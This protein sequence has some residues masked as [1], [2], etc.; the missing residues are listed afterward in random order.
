MR[1]ADL[2]KKSR[3][4]INP[5]YNIYDIFALLGALIVFL[6]IPLTVI[7]L[8]QR[9]VFEARADVDGLVSKINTYRAS[10]GLPALAQDQK[11]VSA[12]CWMANDMAAKNYLSHTDSLG[13]DSPARLAVFGVG[14]SYWRG[15][16]IAAGTSSGSA[17]FD[18]WKNS[19]AHNALLLN[20]NFQRV[21]VG[22]AYNS[23]STYGYYWVADFASG[24]A[25]SVTSQCQLTKPDLVITS[26]STNK[27]I[28]APNE[29]GTATI[30]IKNQGK[31]NAGSFVIEFFRSGYSTSCGQTGQAVSVSS[32]GVGSTTTKSVSFTAPSS[33]GSYTAYAHA[34]G[35]C[36]VSESNESNNLSSG[37]TYQVGK[38][39]L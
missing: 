37:R 17:T 18:A 7:S 31:A 10:K 24:S 11:L 2:F 12:A 21:G 22:A 1:A 20:P 14:G 35:K 30:T 9:T 8:Q 28:Y 6:V 13:R 36:G 15:E 4:V 29:T 38:P 3:N 16:T 5:P 23:S 26:L 19:S 34:D 25:T 27:S 32:L 33:T 39:D